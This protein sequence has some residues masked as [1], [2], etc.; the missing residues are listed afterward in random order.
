MLQMIPNE[1]SLCCL[2]VTSGSTW[3]VSPREVI[4]SVGQKWDNPNELCTNLYQSV[5]TCIRILFSTSFSLLFPKSVGCS[6]VPL[7]DNGCP[8]FIKLISLKTH[9]LSSI[10]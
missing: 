4:S 8:F 9:Y 1:I 2:A 7:F 3:T 5:V 6:H 10:R